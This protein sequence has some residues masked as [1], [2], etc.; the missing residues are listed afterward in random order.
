M[1]RLV[2]S[3][4]QSLDGYTEDPSGDFGWGE[5]DEEVHAFVNGLMEPIGTHLLGR[6]MW[7]VMSYWDSDK[8]LS[9]PPHIAEFARV[10][11]GADKVVYSRTLED[12]ATP[13]A[14]LERA[15]DPDAVR[16]MKREAAR[17]LS[18]AGPELAAEAF[19]A[20]LVDELQLTVAPV[21]VG[22]GKRSLP[23]GVRLDL[24]LLDERR[25]ASGFA[26]LRYGVRS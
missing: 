3:A 25:F 26:F 21:V 22:G 15:F 14:R 20:G 24:E 2:Y 7:E 23:D 10:W 17:D 18:A 12:V 4:I 8:P 5:P 11:Q 19:R 1:G 9:G 13:G 6:R 16:R